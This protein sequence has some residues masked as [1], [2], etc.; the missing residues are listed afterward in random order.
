MNLRVVVGLFV[1]VLLFHLVL[2]RGVMSVEKLEI[3]HP[4]KNPTKYTDREKCDNCGMDRNKWARTRYEFQNSKGSFYT[5]SIHCVAVMGIKIKEEVRNVKVAEYLRPEKMLDADRAFFVVGSTAP[6][7][8]TAKSKIAFSTKEEADKFAAR[9]G[10]I[11]T[12]YEGALN[13]AKTG[14]HGHSRDGHK[15]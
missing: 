5:C 9:Y 3:E 4:I 6:G 2:L 15:H 14:I 12:N 8:M 11:V 1:F 10:G 13:E 7:T